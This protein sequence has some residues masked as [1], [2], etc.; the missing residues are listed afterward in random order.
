MW[1][2]ERQ[3]IAW[4]FGW[5]LLVTAGFTL[6]RR[7]AGDARPRLRLGW[8]AILLIAGLA[9]LLPALWLPVGA[10]YDIESFRMATDALLSGREVYTA[11]LGRHPYLPFQ[12]YLMGGMAFIARA[13]GL[14]FVVAIKLPS[15]AADVALTGLIYHV[16]AGASGRDRATWAALLYA[17]NPVSLLV[18]AYHGQFESVTLLLL[19]L[20]WWLR[21]RSREGASAV[22]LGLAILNKTWPVV[23]L[24]VVFVRLRGWRS[25]AVY[26]SIALGIPV[27][28]S[29]AYLVL[30]SA[31][32]MPMLRRA[33]THRGVAGY[34]GPGAALTPAALL[35]PGLQGVVDGLF[36]LRNGLLLAAVLFALWWTRRQSLLDAFLTLLLAIFTVTTGF[37]IQ[38]LVWLVPFALLAGEERRLRVYS[39][40]ATFMLTVHLFGLHMAPLLLERLPATTAMT[41][42]RLSALP[43]WVVVVVWFAARLREARRPQP[44][45]AIDRG[46]EV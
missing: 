37:G 21:E 32:P 35:W 44:A 3:A 18:T 45:V 39:L 14:P 46:R 11:V 1:T 24:P 43:A 27:L 40:A 9:R 19:A 17:L 5:L 6:L 15:V 7:P 2:N 31:G 34:W 12:M 33:L 10:G 13:T 41:L 25:R 23:F 8:P 36:A 22:A 38:W 4:A 42:I 28:F 16:V 29:V 26:S 30:F 20:A